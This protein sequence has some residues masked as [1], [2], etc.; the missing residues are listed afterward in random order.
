M[1]K[2]IQI[3]RV[4]LLSTALSATSLAVSAQGN[5]KSGSKPS[6]VGVKGSKPGNSD[7]GKPGTVVTPPA[8]VKGTPPAGVKGAPTDISHGKP[9]GENHG[10]KGSAPSG[11]KGSDKPTSVA[12]KGSDKAKGHEDHGKSGSHAE[13]NAYGKNKGELEGKE[14]G[15]ARAAAAKA[16]T[17]E[18]V[19]STEEV[20]VKANTTQANVTTGITNIKNEVAVGVK[21]KAITSAEALAVNAKVAEVEAK[22]KALQDAA[23][24]HQKLVD[25]I[26]GQL[27]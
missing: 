13:G 10:V 1:K 22:I 24:A 23:A 16:K 4:L 2:F 26:K 7:H 6:S 3:S 11:T 19:K 25:E 27:K 5:G 17:E 8:G 15:Q 14:F 12:G 20:I 21:S 18:K 9:Q